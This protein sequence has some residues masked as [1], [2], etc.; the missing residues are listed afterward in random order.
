MADAGD[1]QRQEGGMWQNGL[2]GKRVRRYLSRYM[3]EGR[4]ESEIKWVL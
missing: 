2:P 3:E 1:C 4:S